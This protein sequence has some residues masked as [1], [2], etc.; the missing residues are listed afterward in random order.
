[1][2]HVFTLRA[3]RR[4]KT[5]NICQYLGLHVHGTGIVYDMSLAGRRVVGNQLVSEG[6][7][8]SLRIFL[9]LAADSVEIERAI[10]QSVK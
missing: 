5:R 3:H 9:P 10:V 1:M 2:S 6:A 4:V 7:P 8:L